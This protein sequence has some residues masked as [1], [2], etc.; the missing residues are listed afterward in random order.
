MKASDLKVVVAAY[1]LDNEIIDDALKIVL[2]ILEKLMERTS[3]WKFW[4]VW[5][6]RALISALKEYLYPKPT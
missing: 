2:P 3:G 4:L 1:P 5:G 6:M